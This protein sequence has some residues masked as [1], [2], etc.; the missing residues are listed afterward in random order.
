[1]STTVTIIETKNDEKFR[2][3]LNSIYATETHPTRITISQKRSVSDSRVYLRHTSQINPCLFREIYQKTEMHNG[4]WLPGSKRPGFTLG[5]GRVYAIYH[6]AVKEPNGY[7][8]A[9]TISIDLGSSL[10]LS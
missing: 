9:R 2:I 3:W 1:M 4:T 6:G 7:A 10:F 5:L 8:Q